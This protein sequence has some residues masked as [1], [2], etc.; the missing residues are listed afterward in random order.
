[1]STDYSRK[2]FLVASVEAVAG[3]TL[4]GWASAIQAASGQPAATGA[5]V[6]CKPA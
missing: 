3:V 2:E 6:Y 5:G 1:M 4:T